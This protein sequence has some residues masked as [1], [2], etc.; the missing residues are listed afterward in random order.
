MSLLLLLLFIF[1]SLG[2]YLVVFYMLLKYAF[3]GIVFL[4]KFLF[5]DTISLMQHGIT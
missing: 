2:S 1:I 3:L 5:V 4:V